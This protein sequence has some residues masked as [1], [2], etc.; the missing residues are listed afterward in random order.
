VAIRPEALAFGAKADDYEKGRPDYPPSAIRWL[1]EQLRIESSSTVIDLAAGTGK[2]TR[3]LLP[4]GARV[5]A[6]EPV[7][8]MR[9]TL[10]SVL[11]SAEVLDGTAE[12]LPVP[13]GFADA[14]T[15]GQAFHW[16]RGDEALREVHRALVPG[17]RLGLIWNIRDL[18]QPVQ[19]ELSAVTEPYRGSTPSQDRGAWKVAF[20]DTNLFGALVQEEFVMEQVVDHDQLI[21]RVVSVSFIAGLPADQQVAVAGRVAAIAGR[22]GNPVTL[23]YVTRAYWCQ[24]S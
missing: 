18:D 1:I 6:V 23:R 19:A 22:Y 21:A 16:F 13:D 11:P 4:T 5:I 14:V 10:R 17:G 12:Q 2:L 20:R 9:D 3:A 24:S 8:G 7:A 15:V